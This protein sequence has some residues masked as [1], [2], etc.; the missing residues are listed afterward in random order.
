[1][2]ASSLYVARFSTRL[3]H[4]NRI[5][6]ARAFLTTFSWSRNVATEARVSDMPHCPFIQ[7]SV[8][9]SGTSSSALQGKET[10]VLHQSIRRFDILVLDAIV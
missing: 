10:G 4:W 2:L 6:Q 3:A 5:S 9:V 8:F 7:S 1:M